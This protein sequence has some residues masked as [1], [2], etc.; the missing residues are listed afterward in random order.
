MAG[1]GTAPQSGD[2]LKNSV[3]D[4]VRSLGLK[5]D[6]EVVAARH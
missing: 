6:T 5:V 3:A 2:E 1:K 4:L